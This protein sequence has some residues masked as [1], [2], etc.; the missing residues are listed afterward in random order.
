MGIVCRPLALMGAPVV[1][2]ASHGLQR[3]ATRANEEPRFAARA[4]QHSEKE[5]AGMPKRSDDNECSDWLI[6]DEM[7]YMTKVDGSLFFLKDI[8]I[9][10]ATTSAECTKTHLLTIRQ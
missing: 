10:F 1:D 2:H 6:D 9:L 7:R 8:F 5:A 4:K 3:P